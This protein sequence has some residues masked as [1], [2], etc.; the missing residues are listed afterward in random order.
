MFGSDHAG[1]RA[2]AAAKAD[3]LVRRL[4]L[5]WTEVLTSEPRSLAAPAASA[6]QKLAFVRRH[7]HALNDWE[8]G[9]IRDLAHYR[10]LTPKQVNIVDQLVDKIERGPR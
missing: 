5:T 3:E 10:R 6:A 9:F 1:E 8:I 4:G 7:L 2:A